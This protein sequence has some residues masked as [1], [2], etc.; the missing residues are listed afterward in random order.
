MFDCIMNLKI[1]VSQFKFILHIN[2]SYGKNL[3]QSLHCIFIFDS[4]E[5]DSADVFK[6]TI[7]WLRNEYLTTDT[8]SSKASPFAEN[9]DSDQYTDT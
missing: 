2:F 4:F 3:M 8:N 9:A 1:K 7:P 5:S 6:E